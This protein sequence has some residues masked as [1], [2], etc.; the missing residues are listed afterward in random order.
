M[1]RFILENIY[2]SAEYDS[3]Y[4]ASLRAVGLLLDAALDGPPPDPELDHLLRQLDGQSP[5]RH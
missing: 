5:T 1:R 4:P 3:G 2:T